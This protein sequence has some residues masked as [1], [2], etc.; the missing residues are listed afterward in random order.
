[1]ANEKEIATPVPE[2]AKQA[3]KPKAAKKTEKK[4]AAPKVEKPAKEDITAKD[5]SVK[6]VTV[7]PKTSCVIFENANKVRWYLKG[8]TLEMTVCPKELADRFE[9]YSK[10]R[11]E[12]GRTGK[13][14]GVI[15]KVANNKD[16]ET[17]LAH[18][19][20]VK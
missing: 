14:I 3:A 6:G 11:L 7:T 9:G 19:V 20:P 17:I 18:L 5:I 2:P 4:P 8:H 15:R 12:T 16:L 10:E 1:M 13:I